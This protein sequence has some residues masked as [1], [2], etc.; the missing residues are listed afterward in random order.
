VGTALL[1]LFDA[2]TAFTAKLPGTA[3]PSFNGA[4]G[5]SAVCVSANQLGKVLF[6]IDKTGFVELTVSK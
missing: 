4:K 6:T 2:D 5:R 1:I 3:T